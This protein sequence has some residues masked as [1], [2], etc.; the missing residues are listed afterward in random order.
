MFEGTDT[1]LNTKSVPQTFLCKIPAAV[2]TE[3]LIV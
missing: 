2:I 3:T 1:V